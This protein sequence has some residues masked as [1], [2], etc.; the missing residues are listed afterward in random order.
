MNG[1][2]IETIEPPVIRLTVLEAELLDRIVQKRMSLGGGAAVDVRR[3]AV[4]EILACG[5]V[6]VAKAEGL[7]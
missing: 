2:A 3:F 6:R 5:L 1:R 4:R 7:E